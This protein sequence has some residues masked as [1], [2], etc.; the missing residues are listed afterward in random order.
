MIPKPPWSKRKNPESLED[1]Y[2][3]KDG[4]PDGLMS[5]LLGF[6]EP[7]FSA[8][9]KTER[10]KHF[11]RIMDRSLPTR[12]DILRSR[13]VEDEVLLL[14]AI[15]H[16]LTYPDSHI[17]DPHE[18]A[19]MVKTFFDEARSV[20]TVLHVKDDEYEIGY[21][22]SE[23]MTELVEE[24]TNQPG[25]AAKHLRNA[26]SK[27]FGRSPDPRGACIEATSAIE[28]AAKPVVSPDNERTTLGTLCRDISSKPEK[29]ETGSAYDY[30]NHLKQSD[31][32]VN[33]VLS[34]M[35]MVWNNGRYRHGDEDAPAELSQESAEISVH[36]SVLLVNWFRSGRIRLKQE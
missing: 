7:H 31:C 19:H 1:F 27:C 20:Y 24:E 26:W 2:V 33:T 28:V 4:I 22:Q 13:F 11:E 15:D 6:L 8:R 35:R 12:S 21:R 18:A 5:S 16:V 25:Q 36:M 23:E 10:T 32:D 34:M 9:Y 3:L 17:Q 14:D 30:D 29:W